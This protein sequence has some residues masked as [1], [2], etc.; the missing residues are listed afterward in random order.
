MTYR[1]LPRRPDNVA[2]VL[3]RLARQTIIYWKAAFGGEGLL[4][5]P[6]ESI[7]SGAVG[8]PL[9]GSVVLVIDESL[10]KPDRD[11][12][13]RTVFEH[14]SCL[15]EMGAEVYLWVTDGRDYPVYRNQLRALGVRILAGY[16]Q[17][18]L[19]G[20]LAAR[21][22]GVQ[23]VLLNRPGVAADVLTV[24]LQHTTAP[25]VYYGHDLHFA[26]L[27]LQ[28]AKSGDPAGPARAQ[29]FE[30]L[31]RAIWR[32]VD[33]VTYPSDDE[34]GEVLA[35]EPHVSART[36]APYCFDDF[37]IRDDYP[38][39]GGIFFVGSFS[40][41]PNVQAAIW[42]VREVFPLVRSKHPLAS[43]TIAGSNTPQDVLSLA[44][45]GVSVTGWLSDKALAE[46][47]RLAK[48]GVVPL[49][50]GAGVKLKLVEAMRHGLPTVTTSVGA[51]G[52]PGVERVLAICDD[53]A[54]FADA[55]ATLLDMGRDQWF[56]QSGA[57]THYVQGQFSRTQMAQSLL[58]AMTS[59][60]VARGNRVA[61]YVYS[62]P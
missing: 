39:D 13:S 41:P 3:K 18:D 1:N 7:G 34:I 14:L 56:A 36:L 6:F 5:V 59:A 42:L 61:P 30:K 38:A 26:R 57:Q 16:L 8:G 17:P 31:E 29:A 11:A 27:A 25:V 32:G 47:Y 15:R 50:V 55:V 28:A 62:A 45:D 52:L 40:H 10:P 46:H 60:T 51:Q 49:R 44:G 53:A 24:L 22:N 48:V 2:K 23:Y 21:P 12:G 37:A 58:Q 33:T 19:S 54:Q 43:L 35:R 20:W 9:R 4:P